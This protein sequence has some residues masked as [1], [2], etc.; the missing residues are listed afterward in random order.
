MFEI[1]DFVI[2]CKSERKQVQSHN[3]TPSETLVHMCAGQIPSK[4]SDDLESQD[5]G[6]EGGGGPLN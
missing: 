1:S 6:L 4:T 3:A 5:V 2:S